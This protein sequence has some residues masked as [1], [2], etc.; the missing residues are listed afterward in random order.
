MEKVAGVPVAP[1]P[2]FELVPIEL[3]T[4]HPQNPRKTFDSEQLSELAASVRE[5]GILNPLL[6]RPRG[7]GYEVLAGARRLRAAQAVGLA[8]VP[9]IV[10]DIDDV[11]ALE[12]VVVDN[13]QRS[14]LH[15]LEEALG[16]HY[17]MRAAGY[18]VARVAERVGRSVSYVYDR[19]KLLSLTEQAQKLFRDGSI[20]PGHAVILARL[21]PKDQA[22]A[23]GKPGDGPLLK[24]DRTLFEPEDRRKDHYKPVSVRELQAWVDEHVR[25]DARAADPMLFPETVEAVREATEEQLKVIPITHNPDAKAGPTRTFGP[26]S[27]KRAG[28][29]GSKKCDRAV[30]GVIVVGPGRGKAFPVCT[31]RKRCTV[32]WAKEVKA[33]RARAAAVLKG[34]KTGEQRESVKKS[35]AVKAEAAAAA[36]WRA[37]IAKAALWRKALPR[38]ARELT[39]AVLSSP[40][41][42]GGPL[43]QEIFQFLD[44]EGC[45]WP[46]SDKH[47]VKALDLDPATLTPFDGQK[48]DDVVRNAGIRIALNTLEWADEVQA[49]EL[50]DRFG[51]DLDRILTEAAGADLADEFAATQPAVKKKARRG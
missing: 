1:A 14:D 32:H 8:E 9:A 15:A 13:L 49:K 3:L 7:A 40:T 36:R 33:A 5:K 10:R 30:Q 46:S 37:A 28:G 22:R 41:N 50:A 6:V 23:I 12:V 24:H 45:T 51:V 27:W 17:L 38:I 16:Y 39:A 31:D 43:A 11:D 35:Q 19:L 29:A 48:A 34:G 18:E 44:D 26:R 25:F 47:L 4:E 21:S 2:T 42:P 20:L